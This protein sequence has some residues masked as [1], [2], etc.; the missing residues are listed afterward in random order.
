[1]TSKSKPLGEPNDIKGAVLMKYI[2][3]L[4]V[5]YKDTYLRTWKN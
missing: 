1:M 4:Q 2:L 5:Q 3:S